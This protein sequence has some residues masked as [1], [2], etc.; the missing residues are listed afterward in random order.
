MLKEAYPIA[1]CR[2][3]QQILKKAFLFRG[4][5][6]PMSKTRECQ[7]RRSVGRGGEGRGGSSFV[8]YAQRKS[9]VAFEI[10]STLLNR[11]ALHVNRH[12][13]VVDYK[14]FFCKKIG[15]TLDDPFF[16]PRK[17]S[18]KPLLPYLER[19]DRK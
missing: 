14:N 2:S 9:K 4:N 16:F 15:L 5:N 3:T 7:R 13:V 10:N 17:N 18:Y 11:L 8:F 6:L 12:T 19:T 1:T